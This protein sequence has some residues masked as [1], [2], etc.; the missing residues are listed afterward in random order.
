MRWFCVA[1]FAAALLLGVVS[2][3]AQGVS[4]EGRQAVIGG[5]K[6][7]WD[8]EDMDVWVVS[9]R[10]LSLAANG[11]TCLVFNPSSNLAVKCSL[12]SYNV[13]VLEQ[14]YST[15]NSS[16]LVEFVSG[17]TVTGSSAITPHNLDQNNSTATVMFSA[18]M[19]TQASGGTVLESFCQGSGGISF[20]A[21][22]GPWSPHV[23]WKLERDT[24]YAI[25]VT[26]GSQS[27]ADVSIWALIV[28]E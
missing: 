2:A 27:I 20:S 1:V 14:N 7:S 23:V 22:M 25:R 17:P 19:A 8:I 26:N 16:V 4:Y 13:F 11:S 24:E 6:V 15:T 28:E 3:E 5:P 21:P 18:S 12:V 10:T 9:S